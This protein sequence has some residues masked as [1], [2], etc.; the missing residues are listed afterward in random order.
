MG[1]VAITWQEL[2]AYSDLSRVDLTSW[3]S[4]QV[5]SMSRAYCSMIHEA[6]EHR[7]MKAPFT[8]KLT[9][10]DIYNRG[11]HASGKADKDLSLDNY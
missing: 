11:A 6:G 7:A 1:R 3:E 9:D 10:E 8:P 4:S 5:I 2:K